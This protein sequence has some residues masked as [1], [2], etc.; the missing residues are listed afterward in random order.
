MKSTVFITALV[1]AAAV[2]AAPFTE[3]RH[4][5]RQARARRTLPPQNL[6]D[7]AEI[8]GLGGTNG[9]N[10]QY[11]TNWAGL[12]LIGNSYTSVTGTIVV[13]T[14][15]QP[16]G[17]N[18]RT[19]YA[20]S[21]W[22]GIDGDTCDSAILQT[23]VDFYIQ[24]G[25]VSFDGWYEW[26]PDYSYNFDTFRVSAGDTIRMT[27]TATSTAAGNAMLENMSTGQSVSQSF[28]RESNVLC[29]TN[30]EWIV[31]DFS[32][33]NSLVPLADFTTVTFTDATAVSGGSTVDTSG[34]TIMDIRQNGQVLTSC[35]GGGSEVSCTYD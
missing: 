25:Q 10:V 19:Q 30:A 11:S 7:A 15:K 31:E 2:F 29:E 1:C 18:T 16:S 14:P 26:Y 28:T 3:V 17:G 4:E 35:S 20:A 6:T 9:A 12:V 5:R 23:G 34:A 13:P 33:G 32:D 27:V 24:G 22:V 8:D 21:A